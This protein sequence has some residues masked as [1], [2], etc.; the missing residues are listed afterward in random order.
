MTGVQSIAV[1]LE[2]GKGT[3]TFDPGL[4]EPELLRA[5]VDD[6]GFEA[7]LEGWQTFAFGIMEQKMSSKCC[8]VRAGALSSKTKVSLLLFS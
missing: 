1:S 6:M 2:E 7:S 8:S 3:V 5:A 4:T